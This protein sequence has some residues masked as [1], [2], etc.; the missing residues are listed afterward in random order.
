MRTIIDAYTHNV[1]KPYLKRIVDSSNPLVSKPARSFADRSNKHSNIIDLETRIADMDRYGISKQVTCIFQ[2]LD[3][4]HLPIEDAEEQI[5]LCKIINDDMAEMMKNSKGRIFALGTAPL[6]GLD[7][8]GIE[9]MRRAIKDLGLRG[10]MAITN[11]GGEPVDHFKLFWEEANRLGVPVYLHPV[12]PI[13]STSRPYEDEY[14]LMHVLGWPFET[15]LTMARLVLSGTMSRNPNLR[16]VA[17]HLGAMIPFFSGRINE[18]YD[19]E[20]SMVKPEQGFEVVKGNKPAMEHFGGFYYDTAIG[21]NKHAIEM[22]RDIFGAEKIVFGTDYPFGPKDGI[23]RLANYPKLVE[24]ARF[25]EA[26]KQLIFEE[27]IT[28]L[29]KI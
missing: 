26:E 9:E 28:R 20:M 21:G 5:E 23:L 6:R 16:I 4:N 3:P 17:H 7:V 12:D 24:E 19:K 8:G 22:T 25:S 1:P 15:S 29:L 18:S 10:F 13:T 2:G 27:N 14:D 11:V